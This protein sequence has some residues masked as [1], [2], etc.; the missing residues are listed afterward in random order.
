MARTYDA[1]FVRLCEIDRQ[2]KLRCARLSS[3]DPNNNNAKKDV[4]L[5]CETSMGDKR[6]LLA[7]FRKGSGGVFNHVVRDWELGSIFT[8]QSGL[9]FTPVSRLILPTRAQAGVQT[10]LEA[11]SSK[12]A[13]SIGTSIQ[14]L[15]V[16]QPPILTA[17]ALEIF[18]TGEDSRT[19]I[20]SRFAISILESLSYFSFAP[21]SSISPIHQRSARPLRTYSPLLWDGSC[22]P[23]SRAT[24]S[25]R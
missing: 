11:G 15:S 17:T 18:Y 6:E 10:A 21:S 3:Q 16:S 12:T 19:G 9:P 20:S 5:R 25:L 4:R 8:M 2:P 24:C 22:R 1:Q 7:A 14:R 23:V 13:R